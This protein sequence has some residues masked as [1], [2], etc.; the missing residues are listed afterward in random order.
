MMHTFHSWA[1]VWNTYYVCTV[2]STLAVCVRSG[3][4]IHVSTPHAMLLVCIMYVCEI[5]SLKDLVNGYKH[6]HNL[7]S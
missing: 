5:M 2:T 3:A 6:S 4:Y 1:C 7:R